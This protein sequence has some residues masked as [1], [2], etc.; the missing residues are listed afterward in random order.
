MSSITGLIRHLIGDLVA[1]QGL[2]DGCT[3]TIS[4]VPTFALLFYSLG[5]IK[6]SSRGEW[7]PFEVHSKE[8]KVMHLVHTLRHLAV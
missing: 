5:T 6:C 7:I 4:P 1:P 3:V 2:I 8:I